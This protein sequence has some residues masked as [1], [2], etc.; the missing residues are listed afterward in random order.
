MSGHNKW[1]QIKRQKGAT[2]AQKSKIFGKLVRLIQVEAKKSG[3]NTNSPGLKMAL[4]KANKEN[5]PKD[6][7]ERAIKKASEQKTDMQPVIFEIY[8]PGGVGIIVTA[9]TDNNNRTN[10][11]IKYILRDY[12]TDLGGQGSVLWNFSKNAEGNWIPKSTV[13]V[14]DEDLEKLSTL[15]ETLESQDDVQDVFTNAS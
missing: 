15:V 7:I 10:Q 14:S 5:M 12:N 1:S 11:E 6:T 9:L 8:G 13:D 3:G 4:E 2:D